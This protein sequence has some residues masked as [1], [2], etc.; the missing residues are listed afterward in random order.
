MGELQ[1]LTPVSLEMSSLAGPR[2]YL[3]DFCL[4]RAE[5]TLR[6]AT[7]T[8]LFP[9]PVPPAARCKATQL[10]LRGILR[11]VNGLI[12]DP[13]S[14]SDFIR[15]L[16]SLV[17]P[18]SVNPRSSLVSRLSSRVR[19][20]S[21]LDFHPSIVQAISPNRGEC[22]SFVPITAPLMTLRDCNLHTTMSSRHCIKD[23][24]SILTSQCLVCAVDWQPI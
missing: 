8:I 12:Y 6:V 4:G 24:L 16:C 19:V 15:H 5:G 17:P 21:R 18:I 13:F 11:W 9:V 3:E 2:G 22:A 7:T 20:H 1:H 10:P 14:T 23:T